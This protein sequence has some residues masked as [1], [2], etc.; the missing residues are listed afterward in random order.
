L[1][2]PVSENRDVDLSVTVNCVFA[3]VE[4]DGPFDRDDISEQLGNRLLMSALSAGEQ[5]MMM[6]RWT[7]IVLQ[8]PIE[9]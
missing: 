1:S 6:D 4:C 8:Y 9:T 7:S 2:F 3:V 5:V